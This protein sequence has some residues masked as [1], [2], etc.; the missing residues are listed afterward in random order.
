LILPND[1][2]SQPRSNNHYNSISVSKH[3]KTKKVKYV[4]S[5]KILLY[6][7]GIILEFKKTLEKCIVG[8]KIEP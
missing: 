2:T 3:P 8:R 6:I 7:L 4:K 5:F 1:T